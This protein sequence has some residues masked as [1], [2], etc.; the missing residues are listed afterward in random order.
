M[1]VNE[2]IFFRLNL[3]CR[4]S[5]CRLNLIFKDGLDHI[6]IYCFMIQILNTIDLNELES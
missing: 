2:S 4:D 5:N 6:Y 3:I 1:K